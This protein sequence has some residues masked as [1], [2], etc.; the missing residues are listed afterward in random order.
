MKTERVFAMIFL[1]GI[2]F[3]LSNW[4]GG[5]IIH[6]TA[7]LTLSM[8]YAAGG[9]YFFCDRNLRRQN[10]AL[11][12]VAGLLLSIVPLGILFKLQYW[13]GAGTLILASVLVA[14]PL[15]VALL[16]AKPRAND[17]L[18]TYYK[19]MRWRTGILA[20]LSLLLLLT[21]MSTLLRLQYWNDPELARI[22]TLYYS[23]PENEAYRKQHD[24]YYLRKRHTD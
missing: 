16:I 4:E 15:Y 5:G 22:K 14:L 20:A 10:L 3:K 1:I 2:V 7:A 13:E 6:T 23:N 24:E 21:P 8:L 9:F 12:I 11:S 18:N 17:D 19:N